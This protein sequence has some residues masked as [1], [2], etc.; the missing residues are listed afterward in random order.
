MDVTTLALSGLVAGIGL[1]VALFVAGV[2]FTDASL[3]G[4]AKMGALI[5][6][7]A[8]PIALG[9]GKV[10]GVSKIDEGDQEPRPRR[11]RTVGGAFV[12]VKATQFAQQGLDF[13]TLFSA[14]FHRRT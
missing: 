13:V 3:Q 14:K 1:T 9:L 11:F 5:S 2:A 6:S 10:L 4:A 7:V 8:A 12:N